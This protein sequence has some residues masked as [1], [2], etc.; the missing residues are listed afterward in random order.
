MCLQI[1]ITLPRGHG[2]EYETFI[3][4]FYS[5]NRQNFPVDPNILFMVIEFSTESFF[6]SSD[7]YVS[8]WQLY[9]QR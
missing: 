8:F 9:H 2:K 5:K 7:Q 3:F 6:I 4:L 1:A